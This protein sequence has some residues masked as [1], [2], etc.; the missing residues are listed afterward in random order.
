MMKFRNISQVNTIDE[1]RSYSKTIQVCELGTSTML[2]SWKQNQDLKPTKNPHNKLCCQHYVV[3]FINRCL[4]VQFRRPWDQAWEQNIIPQIQCTFCTLQANQ[5]EHLNLH[6]CNIRLGSSFYCEFALTWA[7][8]SLTM[9]QGL[10]S[11]STQQLR[12]TVKKY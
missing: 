6:H 4:H 3:D 5:R 8:Y 9:G 1:A 12:A 2:A 10:F 7:N 11:N